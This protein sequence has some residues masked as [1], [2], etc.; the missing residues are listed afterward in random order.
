MTYRH[1]GPQEVAPPV[2][3]QNKESQLHYRNPSNQTA[4]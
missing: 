2:W 3:R 4:M 1:L